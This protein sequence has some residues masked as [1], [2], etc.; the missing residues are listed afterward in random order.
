MMRV[1]MSMYMD[2]HVSWWLEM[3]QNSKTKLKGGDQWD[4]QRK[5]RD[6]EILRCQL[7]SLNDFSVQ[8]STWM[9]LAIRLVILYRALRAFSRFYEDD[10]R[11]II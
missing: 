2:C 10:V 8:V 1:G 9:T 7:P 11:C 4:G 6:R 3:D 5:P